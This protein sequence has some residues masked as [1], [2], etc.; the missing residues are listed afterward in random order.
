VRLNPSIIA[1]TGV[2]NYPRVGHAHGLGPSSGESGQVKQGAQ[3][4]E[5]SMGVRI[6]TFYA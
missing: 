5:A 1:A 2:V 4:T 6:S 3:R